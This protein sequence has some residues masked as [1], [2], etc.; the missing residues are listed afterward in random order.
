MKV[1][2]ACSNKARAMVK[3]HKEQIEKL[4]N[5]LLEK[6]TIDVLDII[7]CI[8]DRPFGVHESM[9]EYIKEAKNRK[10]EE[11]KKKDTESKKLDT[12]IENNNKEEN[13]EKET[14]VPGGRNS[15]EGKLSGEKEIQLPSDLPREIID[16]QNKGTIPK[17]S[18]N[19]GDKEIKDS[20]TI[21][22]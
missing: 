14:V 5:L 17:G 8:G 13:K 6:E 21:L 9:K 11:E 19:R 22:K 18:N 4:A 7:N 1:I 15:T 10:I 16:E 12:D 20:E 2:D 3:E